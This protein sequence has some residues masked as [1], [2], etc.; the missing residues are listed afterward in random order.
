MYVRER[1]VPHVTLAVEALDGFRHLVD[2]RGF[3][4]EGLSAREVWEKY[5]STRGAGASAGASSPTRGA[6]A[7]SESGV[8]TAGGGEGDGLGLW[9]LIDGADEETLRVILRKSCSTNG[10]VDALCGAPRISVG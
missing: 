6:P 3:V 1:T 8:P 10:V 9:E 2:G 5:A 4:K 7:G